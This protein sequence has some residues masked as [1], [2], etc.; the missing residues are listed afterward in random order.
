MPTYEY[1]CLECGDPFE[2]QASMQDK[3]KGIEVACPSCGGSMVQQIFGSISVA[4][5]SAGRDSAG[6]PPCCPGGGC[7]N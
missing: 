1:T 7:C 5:R 3:V 2:V 6:P 4:T